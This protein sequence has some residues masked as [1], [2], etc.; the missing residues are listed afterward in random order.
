MLIKSLVAFF[1]T[2]AAWVV[3]G[4]WGWYY[5]SS[6]RLLLF[7]VIAVCAWVLCICFIAMSYLNEEVDESD[8]KQVRGRG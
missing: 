1:V 8:L 6:S 5:P 3:L 4:I 7:L 2:L